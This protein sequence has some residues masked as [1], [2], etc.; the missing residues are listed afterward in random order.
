[1]FMRY[2]EK[3]T[4]YIAKKVTVKKFTSFEFSEVACIVLRFALVMVMPSTNKF[5]ISVEFLQT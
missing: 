2:I 1:M 5:C 4:V 3:L